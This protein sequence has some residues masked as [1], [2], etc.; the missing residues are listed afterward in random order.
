MDVPEFCPTETLGQFQKD[1]E[2]VFETPT[3]ND[4]I[5][6]NGRVKV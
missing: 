5:A 4:N 1:F 2:P 3:N 6:G